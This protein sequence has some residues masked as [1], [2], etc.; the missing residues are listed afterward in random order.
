MGTI[1]SIKSV[2]SGLKNSMQKPRSGNPRAGVSG[3]SKS[4]LRAVRI[5]RISSKKH[6]VLN[7]PKNKPEHALAIGNYKKL[8]DRAMGAL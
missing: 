5:L 3:C 1:V 2:L 6:D 4:L 7:H 8:A